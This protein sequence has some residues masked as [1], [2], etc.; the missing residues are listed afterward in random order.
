MPIQVFCDDIVADNPERLRQV[1]FH[2]S[3]LALTA[4][5]IQYELVGNPPFPRPLTQSPTEMMAYN[6][7]FREYL[8]QLYEAVEQAMENQ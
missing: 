4:L 3:I 6:Q 5:G 7:A 8:V 2:A 1:S